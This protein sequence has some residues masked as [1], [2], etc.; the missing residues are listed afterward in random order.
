MHAYHLQNYSKI[1][2]RSYTEALYN[3][4]N[5]RSSRTPRPG[6]SLFECHWRKISVLVFLMGQNPKCSGY[7][8]GKNQ[9]DKFKY[10]FDVYS[11]RHHCRRYPTLIQYLPTMYL[12]QRMLGQRCTHCGYNGGQSSTRLAQSITGSAVCFAQARGI[13]P[14]LFKCWPIVF[15]AG[16]SL[17]QHW[18]YVPCFPTASLCGWR[19]AFRRQIHQITRLIGPMLV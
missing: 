3:N 18:V 5:K 4:N 1:I 11:F 16:P 15:D 19:F 14:M 2:Y 9:G 10:I 13:H 12:V 17:K 6:F 7:N 8:R